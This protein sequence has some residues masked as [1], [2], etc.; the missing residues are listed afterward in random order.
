VHDY[1]GSLVFIE[2]GG[3]AGSGFIGRMRDGVF[4]LTN[5][6]VVAGMPNVRFTRLDNSVITT[7]AIAAAVGHDI[8]RFAIGEVPRPLPCSDNV[9]ADARIGDDIIVLGNAEGARVIQ[10]LAGK[11]AGIG[12]DRVEITAEF[13]PGNSGSPIVHLKSGKV[14]GIVTFLVKGRFGALTDAGQARVRR[15]GYRL[16]T[17]KQW[18]P[19]S[20]SA[21]QAEK[22][23]IDKVETLTRDLARLIDDIGDD[24][25][26]NTAA[27]SNPALVRPVRDLS[28]ALA[29]RTLSPPDRT[30]AVQSFLASVRLLTQSDVSAARQQLH[31]DFFRRDLTDEAEIRE[32]MF[33]LFDRVLK[34]RP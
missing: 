12:P 18:Q 4:L 7:G 31:Y 13:L 34:A 21:Y 19:V 23:I 26:I 30:R 6:H 16:D 32:K 10:P 8:M 3:G 33:Q 2:G 1:S 15:F 29:N 22:A 17:V 14:I 11:L 24:A 20:W 9:E 28:N 5:Q 27:H 25:K